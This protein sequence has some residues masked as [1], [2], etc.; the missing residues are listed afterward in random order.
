[1]KHERVARLF[2]SIP[3]KGK[4]PA[5]GF[6]NIMPKLHKLIARLTGEKGNSAVGRV[7]TFA[8][9]TLLLHYAARSGK[10]KVLKSL[11]KKKVSF[12]LQDACG[13]TSLMTAIR[14]NKTN[15]ARPA[16]PIA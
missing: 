5:S 11:L 9:S 3:R 8:R 12:N 4:K 14:A 16:E 13:Q 2:L 7:N 6:Q 15:A 10:I 1:M